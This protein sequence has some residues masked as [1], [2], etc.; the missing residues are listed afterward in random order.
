MKQI[1]LILLAA[2]IFPSRVCAQ[3]DPEF[4]KGFIM[5][6]KLHNGVVT[7]FDDSPDLY[8]G[9]IQL[10]P[11]ITVAEHL[12][13]A[14]LIADGFYT[15]KKWQGAFGPTL[16]VKLKTFSAGAFGSAANLN[17]SVN[18]LWGTGQQKL[19]GG[20]INF[21]LLNILQLSVFADKDY[22]LNNWWFQTSIGFRISKKK[23]NKE[24]F[25]Q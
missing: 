8:T 10:V 1:A 21:D 6:A 20:A 3:T 24:P 12:L 25:N 11:M 16:A 14:G 17:L 18:Y 5:Y 7:S 13:R 9:G 19:I 15:A 2:I 23:V 22:N 4:P